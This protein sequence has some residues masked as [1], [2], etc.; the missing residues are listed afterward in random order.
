M[1]QVASYPRC[2]VAVF[3]ILFVVSCAPIAKSQAEAS[4]RFA[5]QDACLDGVALELDAMPA[6]PNFSSVDDAVSWTSL[7]LKG[8][9]RAAFNRAAI[10]IRKSTQSS[11]SSENGASGLT[12]VKLYQHL[13]AELQAHPS[14]K[15][16]TGI[17]VPDLVISRFHEIANHIKGRPLDG[18]KK[19]TFA[20]IF[21]SRLSGLELE[22]EWFELPD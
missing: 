19:R 8:Q 12:P 14:C 9:L 18:Y 13:T 16:G 17:I 7:H 6:I 2:A 20:L 10:E 5:F 22:G 3:V 4:H 1:A 21:L 15:D 11:V